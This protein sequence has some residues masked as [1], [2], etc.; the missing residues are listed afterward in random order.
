MRFR[1]INIGRKIMC[2]S[3]DLCVEGNFKFH[4]RDTSKKA[5]LWQ[6]ARGSQEAIPWKWKGMRIEESGA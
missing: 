2:M 5:T 1:K 3:F 4:N 6:E